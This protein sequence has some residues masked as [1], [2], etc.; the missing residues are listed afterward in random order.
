MNIEFTENGMT[1]DNLPV[2]VADDDFIEHLAE[3]GF[4]H[5]IEQDELYIEYDDWVKENVEP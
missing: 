3:H 1:I 4:D 2:Y 5:S